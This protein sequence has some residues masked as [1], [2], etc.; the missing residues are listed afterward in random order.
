MAGDSE[1]IPLEVP[2]ERHVRRIDE[3]VRGL[4]AYR[5][6]LEGIPGHPG[7]FASIDRRMTAM[8]KTQAEHGAQIAA[9]RHLGWKI[10]TAAVIAGTATSIVVKV[11]TWA[12]AQ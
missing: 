8:E 7:T 11:I 12:L 2:R 10:V 3:R 4:E 5:Q 9:V 1:P 6:V